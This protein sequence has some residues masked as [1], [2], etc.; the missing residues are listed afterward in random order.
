MD[1]KSCSEDTL[2][3]DPDVP[4]N[5]GI[6][7]DIQSTRPKADDLIVVGIGAS[8]GGLEALQAMVASLSVDSGLSFV[9]AQHIYPSYR[10]MM[11]DLLE[12]DSTIPVIAARDG[13]KLRPNEA[14][15]CPPNHNIE[16]TRQNTIKLTRYDEVRHTPRPSVD[17]LIGVTSFFLDARVFE[18]LR[19]ELGRY[20]LTKKDKIIRIWSVGCGTGEE[21]Y[22]TA[23]LIADILGNKIDD[24]KTLLKN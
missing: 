9:I 3:T 18:L 15:S 6:D 22:S 13:Q 4:A 17:M 12:K 7:E 10:S 20:I 16:I 2:D 5:S 1:A 24:W 23:I 14:G 8:A 19:S 21:P 11:V